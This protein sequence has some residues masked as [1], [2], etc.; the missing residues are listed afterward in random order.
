MRIALFL[1][2]NILSYPLLGQ[3]LKVGVYHNPPLISVDSTG[4]V[5][6]FTVELLRAIAKDKQWNLEYSEYDFAS[7]LKALENG[8]I[9]IM[10]TLAYSVERDSLFLLNQTNVATNWAKIY[11]HEDDNFNYSAIDLLRDTRIAAL[12]DDFYIKNGEDGLLDIFDE[13]DIPA[14]IVYYESYDD[15]VRAIESQ[16]VELGLLNRYYGIFNTSDNEVVKTPINVAYVSV[17]YGFSKKSQN[18]N[19]V[20]ELDKT[21]LDLIDN[22]SSIYYELERRHLSFEGQGF[23]PSWLWQIFGIVMLGLTTLAIFT[24]LL[25]YQVKKKTTELNESNRLLSKSE[26]EARLAAHTI[27][28]SQDI[29]FWFLP[30]KPFVNVNEAAERLTGYSSKE[31]MQMIPRDLLASNKNEHHYVALSEGNWDGHLLLEDEFKRKD[32][33]VFPVELSLDEFVLDGQTYICGFARNITERVRAE[34]ELLEKNKELS[35]LYAINQ[36]TANRENS[37]EK[38][39]STAIKIIPIAWQYPK[40]T[41]VR[42]DVYGKLYKSSNY[43]ETPWQLEQ[44]LLEG[45]ELVGKLSIGYVKQPDK[46]KDTFLIEE[47]N[48]IK[49]IAKEFSDM[50]TSRGTERKIMSTILSTEDKERSRISKELHDSVGQT[51]SAI[52]LHLNAMAKMQALSEEDKLKLKEVEDLVKEAIGESRSVSHNLMPPA[53]T[54]LGFSYAIENILEKLEGVS[55]IEYSFHTNSSDRQVPKEVEFALFR[56]AQESINNI[57]KYSEATKATIQYLVYEDEILMS[58]E[59]NG[60]GFDMNKVEKNHNFGLNSMRNRALSLG[61]EI[62]IDTSPG[63]GTSVHVQVP[64]N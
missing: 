26:H 14:E 46:G 13:L 58:V 28:A 16:D 35:C 23:I 6:G 29:G 24:I 45:E 8:D 64:F 52:S 2:L 42:I 59:D 61:G 1:I 10:P 3:T 7:C 48:L 30:G 5:S 11:K 36:L 40:Q 15:V 27:E 4:Q 37:Q 17:R 19:L 21:L 62:T 49:A 12:K 54:D 34:N 9:D 55:S 47:N 31:L 32:G 51:L 20:R 44:D 53:L 33:T 41:F 60:Q 50:L 63:K 57:I 56:I 25:Q 38:V 18:E 39:F 22:R 43:T